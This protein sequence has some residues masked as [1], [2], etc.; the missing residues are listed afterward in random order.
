MI[1]YVTIGSDDLQRAETF[2]SAFLPRLGYQLQISDEGLGYSLSAA[3]GLPAG[4][5]DVY[6]KPPHNGKPA[7]S[8]NGTMVAF[9]VPSQQMVRQLHSA[10][11]A[12]GGQNEGDPG[13]RAAYGAHFYVSYLRDP[14]GNKIALFCDSRNEPG[15]PG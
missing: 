4:L 11:L 1:G 12:A 7:S 10:A 15:R 6:V 3:P 14:Q 13:F 8:G 5:P 2:Y 9:Q